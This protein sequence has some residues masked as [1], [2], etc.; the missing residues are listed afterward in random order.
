MRRSGHISKRG[1]SVVRWLIVESGWRVVRCSP[2]M[3]EFFD[4]VQHGQKTRKKIAIVAVA[5]KLLSIMR[6]M[7]ITGE[8]YNEKMVLKQEQAV[9]AM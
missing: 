8:V 6:A 3:R 9:L 2:A 7:L 1:P 5:R 4:R